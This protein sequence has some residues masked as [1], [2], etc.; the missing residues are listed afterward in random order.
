MKLV[1]TFNIVTLGRHLIQNIPDPVVFFHAPLDTA[2]A[3]YSINLSRIALA[4][5]YIDIADSD[6]SVLRSSLIKKKKVF[7]YMD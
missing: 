6:G 4:V 7:W 3:K 1:V 5:V 2:S